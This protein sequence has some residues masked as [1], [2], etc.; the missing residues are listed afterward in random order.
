MAVISAPSGGSGTDPAAI[1]RQV[2][3]LQS[4]I[5]SIQTQTNTAPGLFSNSGGKVALGVVPGSL[6][7]VR[8]PDGSISLDVAD[9]SGFGSPVTIGGAAPSSSSYLPPQ[10][11]AGIPTTTQFPASGNF[12]WYKNTTTGGWYFTLNFGGALVFQDF[13]GF[14]GAISDAQHGARGGGTLHTAATTSTAGFATGAQIT[15]LNSVNTII[16]DITGTGTPSNT[17]NATTFYVGGVPVISA[18]AASVA[19]LAGAAT[20]AQVITT[21]NSIITNI[22]ANNFMSP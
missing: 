5:Q 9:S 12:G 19:L 14:G 13:A 4:S 7:A 21:V 15:L 18:R 8:M 16:T 20:L 1:A 10:T 3:A 6:N 17:L 2:R 11:H 22:K